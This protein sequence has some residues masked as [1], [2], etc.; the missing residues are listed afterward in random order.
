MINAI[1]SEMHRI[2]DRRAFIKAAATS[3]VGLAMAS[4]FDQQSPAQTVSNTPPGTTAP[5]PESQD[6]RGVVGCIKPLVNPPGSLEDLI[7]LLPE[8]IGVIPAFVGFS[9]GT[10]S[11]FRTGIPAYEQQVAWLASEHCDIIHPEGAPPFMILGREGEA[12]LTDAWEK[13]YK[14]PIFTSG[15]NQVNALHALGAKTIFG[16]TYF[17]QPHLNELFKTYFTDAGF[18]VVGMEPLPGIAFQD[19]QDVSPDVVYSF[20]HRNFV[21]YSGV[22]CIY[23]LGSQWRVLSIIEPLEQ[24]LEVPVLHPECA[25]AWEI[26]KRLRVRQK[27]QGYG[28]LLATL[29]GY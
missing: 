10:E 17:Q 16:A 26:Q 6:W 18:K 13:K 15:Q 28:Q 3:G 25:R 8:G 23:M 29:P 24:D 21:K 7:R 9:Q 12:R 1:K 11:E 2:K 19:V 4:L 27:L 20:I 22:D 14:T 5:L